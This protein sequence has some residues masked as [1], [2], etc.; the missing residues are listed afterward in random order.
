MNRFKPIALGRHAMV[1]SNRP[2]LFRGQYARDQAYY[3]GKL[4]ISTF[5]IVS[6]P[7]C[8]QPLIPK[9]LLFIAIPEPQPSSWP[10]RPRLPCLLAAGRHSTLQQDS[11]LHRQCPAVNLLMPLLKLLQRAILYRIQ[12][13]RSLI[14]F[15]FS[16]SA[17]S[18][19]R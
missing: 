7:P 6:L 5:N 17:Q 11:S 8:C 16:L 9:F 15:Q 1:A 10:A 12:P 2:S 4:R 3:F 14:L 18:S 13:C 19:D